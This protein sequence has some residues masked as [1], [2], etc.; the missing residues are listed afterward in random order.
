MED[1][2]P[3]LDTPKKRKLQSQAESLK[4]ALKDFERR[5]AAAHNGK[6][7]SREDIK[8]NATI[9]GKYKEY[10]KVRDILAGKLS[11]EALNASQRS[12]S[13]S[14]A[15][16]HERTDSAVS[17]TPR[18]PSN[19]HNTPKNLKHPNVLDPYDP[20]ASASPVPLVQAVGPTPHRDGTIMGIFDLLSSAGS[21]RSLQDTPSSKKRKREVAGQDLEHTRLQR[22]SMQYTPS[23]Q[24]SYDA[25][26][27]NAH[28]PPTATPTS[29]PAT[30]RRNHSRTPASE[31]KRFMLE[32]FFA[33]PSAV[34]FATMMQ[35]GEADEVKTPIQQ[36]TPLRDRVLGAS[37]T[38]GSAN[39]STTA[40]LD[41]TPPYLKRSFSFKERLLSATTVAPDAK[42]GRTALS[43]ID[44]SPTSTRNGLPGLRHLKFGPKPLSQI[45]ADR[46]TQRKQTEQEQQSKQNQKQDLDSAHGR[47]DD[48]EDSLDDDLDALREMESSEMNITIGNSQPSGTAGHSSADQSLPVWKKKGQKR[49]TRRTIMRPVRM[50]PTAAPKFV[51]ADEPEDESFYEDEEVTRVEET[52]FPAPH[53]PE[54]LDGEF[55]DTEIDHLIAQAESADQAQDQQQQQQQ[56]PSDIENLT[57]DDY[58]AADMLSDQDFTQLKPHKPT[59]S[60]SSSRATKPNPK[61]KSTCKNRRPSKTNDNDTTDSTRKINPNALSHTNFR[62]LKIRN[63]NS[64]AK[65]KGRFG[66]GRR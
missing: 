23:H 1:E 32:H 61:S 16:K 14:R 33:T 36:R 11:V 54:E 27:T 58:D 12:Q 25:A 10:N 55:S 5:H 41:A 4:L 40:A 42:A 9:S 15:R 35:G 31:S 59:N 37:V 65:G 21:R 17:V 60:K 52:Q 49:T 48:F 62:S 8:A 29:G 30:H 51:A 7:P 57:D 26:T 28:L 2:L 38:K 20:P 66:R 63:K 64:K 13:Q 34:R 24:R 22:Q 45:I 43:G 39:P 47:M 50:K 3:L 6:K 19:R 46:E 56:P 18:R 44:T 53:M